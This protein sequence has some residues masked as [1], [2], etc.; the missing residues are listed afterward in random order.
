MTREEA[1]KILEYTLE[2]VDEETPKGANEAE[3]IPMAIEALKGAEINCVHCPRYFETE[4]ETGVHSHCGDL[5]S[6]Q[7]ATSIP[8]IP[9]E[10]RKVFRGED[11][12]F[13]TGWNEALA[14]VNMLPSADRPRG[15]WHYSDGKPAT[16]GR[17]FGVIC[18][19]CGTESEY[20]T[21]F[22][23]ECGADMRGDTE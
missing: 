17:S 22:C 8:I 5:I 6:R 2:C 23:G 9:K 21:N 12:A 10:H 7:A 3:A 13:E 19:Q 11:D 15:R 14:C 4:D 20:C 1:I 18:D 16:I